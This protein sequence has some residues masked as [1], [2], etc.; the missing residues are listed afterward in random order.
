MLLAP[1]AVV[2]LVVVLSGCAIES[3]AASDVLAKDIRERVDALRAE[4]KAAAT[5]PATA[6]ARAAVLWDWGNAL[7]LAG[8]RI[9]DSLPSDVGLT[10]IYGT[11]GRVAGGSQ[12]SFE[13]LCRNLDR[14]VREL[15]IIESEPEALGAWAIAGDQKPLA[16]RSFASIDLRYTVGPRG[17]ATGGAFLIGAQG[18]ID[19]GAVQIEDAKADGYTTIECSN[20]AARFSIASLPLTGL[21]GGNREARKTP[22]FRLEGT[23][24]APGDI[25]TFHLGDRRSGSRGLE[26][27]TS[28]TDDLVFPIYVD[29]EGNGQFMSGDWP[30][31]RVEGIELAGLTVF[32]P[33]VVATGETFD[34]TVRAEDR[35]LNRATSAIPAWEITRNGKVMKTVPAGGAPLQL[36]G[37]L[38]IDQ[39]GIH[40]FTVRSADGKWSATSNPV[41]AARAPATRIYWGETHGHTGLAEGQGTAEQY[42]RYG[43][44]DAR[45]DFLTLSEHDMWMDDAEWKLLDQLTRETT[46]GGRTVSFLGYEW[47][48]TRELGGH[49]NVFF[50]APGR[51]RVPIQK[52]PRLEQLYAGLD[53]AERANDVLVIPHAHV[54]ADWRKNDA[55]IERVVEIVSNHGTFEWFGNKYLG[56]GFKVGFVGAA[57]DHRSR[58][59]RTGS[60]PDTSQSGGLAAALAPTKDASAIFDA[61]RA[62]STY[63]TSG[64]RILLEAS[65][66]GKLPGSDQPAGGPLKL[67]CRVAGTSPID[68]IEV[69]KNGEVAYSRSYL[70]A[71]LASQ[72]WVQV[73][74]ESSSAVFGKALDNPRAYR[75]WKGT[76]RVEGARVVSVRP[77]FFNTYRAKAA[78]DEKDPALVRFQTETRGRRDVMLVE[79]EGATSTTRFHFAIDAAKERRAAPTLVRPLK[80]LAAVEAT[81]AFDRMADGRMEHELPVDVHTDRILL[82]TVDP[83]APLD[84][85]FEWSDLGKVEPG[86]YVYLRVTQLDGGRAWSSPFFFVSPG[87]N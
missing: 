21:H 83:E 19:A 37:E 78:I 84:R 28:A 57:D 72:V 59:G 11:E 39:P 87:A 63:A 86:D 33:S 58:P 60:R 70:T 53:A 50:R 85:E 51:P 26:I 62:R 74:F 30:R 42:F 18:Q 46:E 48:S 12:L 27:Q 1:I 35:H 65:A 13:D 7:A 36:V 10:V 31:L 5:T 14:Y 34:L 81:L 75:P 71:P 52:A 68:Q 49:H 38:S 32:A 54:A 15:D 23:A 20:P 61:L 66:N 76:L 69:V 40:R 4:V 47:T 73:A 56:N 29:F 80:E 3:R 16:A 43:V 2:A 17:F 45:M 8:K 9:P 6:A 82:Q 55:A 79:L 67:A 25:V 41:L 24:L 64:E 22:A 77:V 44:E